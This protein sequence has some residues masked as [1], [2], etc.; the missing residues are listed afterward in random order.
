[1][2]NLIDAEERCE[3]LIKSKIQLEAK[4]KELN[5]RL[6][7]EE[8]VNSD[9]VAKKRNL[10]DKCSSLKRDIDDLE[11]TLT[12]VEK[13]KHATENKVGKPGSPPLPRL[14]EPSLLPLRSRHFL[15]S[16]A[17]ARRRAVRSHQVP[18]FSALVSLPRRLFS[19]LLLPGWLDPKLPTP[20]PSCTK[21][22][23]LNESGV[24]FIFVCTC[25]RKSKRMLPGARQMMRDAGGEGGRKLGH[26]PP[27]EGHG[28]TGTL[29]CCWQLID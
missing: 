5:E 10:E 29:M 7:E 23:I 8:E 1:M 22:G 2:E 15:K 3:G 25:L 18:S 20:S 24:L 16:E 13:E 12:K 17:G 27:W 6:E 26:P 14:L 19:T 11:L 21:Q 9:L 28:Q 4:V